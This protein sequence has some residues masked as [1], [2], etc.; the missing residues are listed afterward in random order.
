MQRGISSW[1][2]NL[3]DLHG[4]YSVR[5]FETPQLIRLPMI[6]MEFSE[7]KPTHD[8]VIGDL[9]HYYDDHAMRARQHE[10][11][12]A[13]ATTILGAIAAAIVALAGICGLS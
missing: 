6:G 13:T 9:W 1:H 4:G 8:A 7:S 11:L 5:Q 10:N 3:A 2:P 12:R